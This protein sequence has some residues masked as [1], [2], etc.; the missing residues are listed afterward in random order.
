MPIALWVRG[1]AR[2]AEVFERAVSVVGARAA[3]GYGE[4]VAAELS[5]GLA[6]LGVT[7]VSGAAYGID[8][9]AH[10]GV[11]A[12]EGLTVAVL[13]CGI[14]IGYPSGHTA[15][16]DR[17]AR[18]GLVISEYAPGTVPARHR[19][20]V[21]N[22]LIA[23]LSTGTVVV[24]AGVRRGARNTAACASALGKELMAVPGPI[25]SAMSAG[26]HELIRSGTAIPVS[27]VAEILES[28]G[29]MGE[30]IGPGPDRQA[31]PTDGLSDEAL[32]V[33]EALGLRT[34]RGADRISVD[35]GL[36]LDRVRALLPELELTSLAERTEDGWRRAVTP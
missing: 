7:V 9:A 26:C 3:T 27:S 25:T 8:G 29:R 13:G 32:R 16:L 1:S 31:R 12:A 22:R 30:G 18:D 14:D 6:N 33:H 28:V 23:A 2:P 36:A 15:L 19:F 24:E 10:R 4:H 17:I 35:S 21:R 34:G 11:L 5:Y 20:L